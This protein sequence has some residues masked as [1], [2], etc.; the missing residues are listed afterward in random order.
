MRSFTRIPIVSR[1]SAEM[2]PGILSVQTKRNLFS[3]TIRIF[4]KTN[5]DTSV[6]AS[7]VIDAEPVANV[8][9]TP[10][11]ALIPGEKLK[12]RGQIEIIVANTAANEILAKHDEIHEIPDAELGPYYPRM[13]QFEAARPLLKLGKVT[14]EKIKVQ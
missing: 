12:Q 3:S 2:K 11:R 6:S 7:V 1:T 14:I 5:E 8:G 4:T 10:M 13:Y 9:M